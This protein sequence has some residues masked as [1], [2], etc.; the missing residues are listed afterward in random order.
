MKIYEN[1]KLRSKKE[2]GII[3]SLF[4]FSM[5][6]KRLTS[7]YYLEYGNLLLFCKTTQTILLHS[8]KDEIEY[9]VFRFQQNTLQ[10]PKIDGEA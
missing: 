4:N 7:Q 5:V 6:Y 2:L 10:V 9:M 1:N 3:L 8:T